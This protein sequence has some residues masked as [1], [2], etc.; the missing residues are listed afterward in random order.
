MT[1]AGQLPLNLT[2]CLSYSAKNFHKHSGVESLLSQVTA[3]LEAEPPKFSFIYGD[4]RYGKTHLSIAL[5]DRLVSLGLRPV[6][7]DGGE[8]R[9]IIEAGAGNFIERETLIVDDAQKLFSTIHV[10]QSGPVVKFFEE[11]KVKGIG[12]VLFSG[13]HVTEFPCDEHVMSRLKGC[14]QLS[15]GMP[16]SEQLQKVMDAMAKQRGLALGGRRLKFVERRVQRSIPEIERYIA[17]LQHL[18]QVMGKKV[19]FRTLGD[20]LKPVRGFVF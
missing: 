18:S 5:A 10:G 7:I 2:P 12:L 4:S 9:S 1:N 8:F 16:E 11:L 3:L 17:R 13:T 19:S 6:L 14:V 15:I 20:A